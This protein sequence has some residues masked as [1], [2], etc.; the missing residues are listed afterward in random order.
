MIKFSSNLNY[1]GKNTVH[2]SCF[3]RCNQHSNPK[4]TLLDRAK[5]AS[6][7]ISTAKNVDFKRTD[8]GSMDEYKHQDGNHKKQMTYR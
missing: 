4:L 3:S 1:D 8:S 2:L 5:I 7:I 6:P